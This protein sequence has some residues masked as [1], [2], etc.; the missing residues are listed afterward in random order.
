[1][2]LYICGR[3]SG[4]TE[5]RLKFLLAEE[6]L[7]KSGYYPVNPAACVPGTAD[8]PLA[9]RQ[10]IRLMLRCDGVALLPDWEESRGAKIE[11]A[12]ARELGMDVRPI[13]EWE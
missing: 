9:M 8:W 10:A 6:R 2:K 12:L 5:Y 3:I 13:G 4:E 1:M 7:F 11:E